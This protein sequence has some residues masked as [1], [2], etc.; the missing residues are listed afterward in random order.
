MASVAAFQEQTHTTLRQYDATAYPTQPFRVNKSLLMLTALRAVSSQTI[1][2][3]FFK[4]TIGSISI[5]RVII[6][7][8]K[9]QMTC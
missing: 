3:V 7:M 2:D 9:S 8:Y 6:D 4:K 1:E 5:E